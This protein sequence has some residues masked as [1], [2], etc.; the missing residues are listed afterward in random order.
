VHNALELRSV[1]G[2]AA[3]EKMYHLPFGSA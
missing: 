1:S 2:A 3:V